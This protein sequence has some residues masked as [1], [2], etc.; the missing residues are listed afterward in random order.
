[1]EQSYSLYASCARGLAGLL[2][3]ELLGLGGESIREER[4]GVAFVGSLETAYRVC[5][6][7]RLASR[8]VLELK[9]FDAA[10]PEALYA[11]LR[12]FEWSEHLALEH[13]FAV[14]FTQRN[15]P[16]THSHFAALRVKDAIVDHLRERLGDRPRVDVSQPDLRFHVHADGTALSLS[17]NLSGESLHRRAYRLDTGPAPLKETLAAALLLRAGWPQL[18]KS[19]APLLDPMCGSGTLVIEA[20]MIAADLAPGLLHKRFG[21]SRWKGHDAALWQKLKRD[22]EARHQ[23]VQ[24]RPRMLGS[25][26]DP[27]AIEAARSNAQRA[28]LQ[29]WVR[30]YHLDMARTAPLVEGHRA[31]LIITN[32]PYG[33]R[34]GAETDLPGLYARFGQVL[35]DNFGSW[36]AAVLSPDAD[37]VAALGLRSKRRSAFMNGPIACE[38]FE[39]DILAQQD[40]QRRQQAQTQAL[41]DLRSQAENNPFANRLRKNMR[42]LDSWA[43]QQRLQ[44]YRLYDAD[45]PEFA[46]AV[47]RYADHLQ[48]S[49]DATPDRVDQKKAKERIELALLSVAKVTHVPSERIVVKQRSRQKGE[50]QYNSLQQQG[51][52]LEVH[53]GGLKY[54]VNL[55]DYHDTGLFLDGRM[56]RSKIF[57]LAKGKRFLNLFAYTGAATVSAVAGGARSS[58]SIDLSQTYLD[59]A[60]DNLQLNKLRS[61]E[62]QFLRADVLQWLRQDHETFDLIYLDPPTFSNSKKMRATLDIQ[63]DHVA[64][65]QACLGQLAPQGTLIFVCNQRRFRLDKQGLENLQIQDTSA[66]TVPQDFTRRPRIHHSFM[67]SRADG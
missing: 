35:R 12:P 39:F 32:P 22:A 21:F 10:D 26:F 11:V 29:D 8:V 13:S 30:F 58:L 51:R 23:R 61:P 64:L 14:D 34:L 60:R 31:G 37:L 48:V 36:R 3:Q 6:W 5:L 16:F 2:H 17:L 63:R 42:R 41:N 45:I 43:K 9:R 53:E 40:R 33:V 54:W 27:R 52:R 19:A 66:V 57:Q 47:D 62:H 20:A 49:V 65:I 50:S 4:A 7:S 55:W 59:W 28:G 46:L 15:S 25:D 38:L 67:I 24:N 1:M 18:A 44:A 56:V